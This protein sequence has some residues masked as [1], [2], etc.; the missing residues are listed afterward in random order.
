VIRLGRT[1]AS[2]LTVSALDRVFDL[3]DGVGQAAEL[4]VIFL[5]R[6]GLSV[7]CD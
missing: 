6:F 4:P 2:G 7:D 5:D 3:Y 1:F